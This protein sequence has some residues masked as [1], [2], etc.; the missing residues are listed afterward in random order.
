MASRLDLNRNNNSLCIRN[1]NKETRQKMS[2]NDLCSTVKSVND[3]LP[4]RCVGE[5]AEEKIY[6]LYQYFGIF[7]G[8]MKNKWKLNYIEI[9]S[10]PGRCINRSSGQEFD[11]TA[12]SILQHKAFDNINKALFYDYSDTVVETLNRRISDLGLSNKAEAKYGD[13]NNPTSICNELK[14]FNDNSLNL[15]LIDPTDCSV[16]FSLLKEISSCLSRFDLII[17]V[18][19]NTDFNRNIPMAFSDQNRAEKYIRFLGDRD[20]FDSRHNQ[21]L[22]D[23]KDYT[24]LRQYFRESYK[25]SLR[26]IGFNHFDYTP[27]RN[28]Y[29][30]LFA[31]SSSKGIEFWQKATKVIDS[32]GQRS[33]FFDI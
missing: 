16:P 19:T 32:T 12:I 14:K 17:N 1:C 15:V 10:G 25:Q 22:C 8:G 26:K 4:V 27:I 5:W 11:G 7:A 20:F 13:Y 33:L 3:N 9:C 30:I 28:F 24:T 18:A 23:M 31:S 2:E 6:L 21:A 29:D